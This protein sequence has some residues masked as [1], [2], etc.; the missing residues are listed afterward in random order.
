MNTYTSAGEPG[1]ALHDLGDAEQLP[2][3]DSSS[4]GV[5]DYL[6]DPVVAPAGSRG[7]APVS[8]AIVSP[9]SHG[10]SGVA[11]ALGWI[12]GGGPGV[13]SRMSATGEPGCVGPGSAWGVSKGWA[14]PGCGAERG[15]SS[16]QAS[17]LVGGG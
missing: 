17:G 10:G 11:G 7:T 14:A 13:G 3:L 12:G 4:A 9:D 8:A 2:G 6:V 15:W 1:S 5:A 16:A